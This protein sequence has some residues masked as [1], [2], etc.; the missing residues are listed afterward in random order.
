[1]FPIFATFFNME[2]QNFL[3][4]FTISSFLVFIPSVRFGDAKP[5]RDL[6]NLNNRLGISTF[7]IPPCLIR[8]LTA[9]I[10]ASQCEGTVK[11]AVVM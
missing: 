3:T 2:L 10:I 1:M 5:S 4:S 11:L 7:S 6:T 9:A 8:N